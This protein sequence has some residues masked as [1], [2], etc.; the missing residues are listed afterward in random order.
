MSAGFFLRFFAFLLDLLIVLAVDFVLLLFISFL[1]YNLQSILMIDRATKIRIIQAVKYP[2]ASLF[3]IIPW[4]YFSYYESS[5]KQATYGKFLFDIRVTDMAGK[6]LSFAKASARFL[7]KIL[8]AVPAF[9]GYLL[10]LF[11]NDKRALHDLICGTQVLSGKPQ[12]EHDP[13]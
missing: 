11:T 12:R 4:L 3:I 7:C 9:G 8:S 1:D 6:K 10:A 2:L 5:N 13:E